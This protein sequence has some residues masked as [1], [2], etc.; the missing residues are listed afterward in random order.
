[1]NRQ[2]L[3]VAWSL[4]C[5][6]MAWLPPVGGAP[7]AAGATRLRTGMVYT[8]T[9]HHRPRQPVNL[10]QLTLPATDVAPSAAVA[11]ERRLQDREAA[12]QGGRPA[13]A[14]APSR[15]T[16][17][18]TTKRQTGAGRHALDL[19]RACPAHTPCSRARVEARRS[20][21][22][23]VSYRTGGRSGRDAHAGDSI[24]P[25]LWS[26]NRL[27]GQQRSTGGC[28]GAVALGRSS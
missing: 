15:G 23:C 14:A 5:S 17:A 10:D 1:M 9:L 26:K 20:G 27:A 28:H 16:Q 21:A 11:T 18:P 19:G 7:L 24:G 8:T 22:T 6:P 3:Q 4:I 25:E 13:T 2:C 12:G